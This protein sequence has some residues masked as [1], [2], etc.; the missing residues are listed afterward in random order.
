MKKKDGE[1]SMVVA[2]RDNR[3]EHD[4]HI[5]AKIHPEHRIIVHPT[6]NMLNNVTT[7]IVTLNKYGM[8][9][10]TEVDMQ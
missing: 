8:S 7:L 2:L 6:D 3:M 5:Q 4:K 9:A 10:F 1:E